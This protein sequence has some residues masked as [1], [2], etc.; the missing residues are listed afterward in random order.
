MEAAIRIARTLEMKH[1]L[2]GFLHSSWGKNFF[3]FLGACY[4]RFVHRTLD[5]HFINWSI[6][7]TYVA[8][9]RP[10]IVCFWHGRMALMPFAWRW[11][12]PFH[13]LLSH[14]RD[15]VFI[16]HVLKQFGIGA[17]YG[18][19][20]RGGEQALRTL[21]RALDKGEL[22]G[23][24]PDGPRGPYGTVS[25]GVIAAARLADVDIVPIS[26]ACQRRLLLK[27]WDRFCVPLPF[28]KAVFVCGDALKLPLNKPSDQELE[29]LCEQ[30]RNAL[31]AVT[32]TADTFV[33]K[34]S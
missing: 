6:L 12:K 19:T 26:Y 29:A 8:Q 10:V 32:T 27:T 15:G 14:H 22:V 2:R 7:D 1:R 13:M 18:S 11:K 25:K 24:T 21:I 3:S 23:I 5:C 28:G 20:N 34:T 33:Q 17:I 16:Q 31:E 9:E 30:L 4:L